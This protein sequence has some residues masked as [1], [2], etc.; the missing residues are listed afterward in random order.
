M[1]DPQRYRD[2]IAG[3]RES[4]NLTV[5]PPGNPDDAQFEHDLRNKRALLQAMINEPQYIF[6]REEMEAW[7]SK[8]Q[9]DPDFHGGTDDAGLI[10]IPS[11]GEQ[12]LVNHEAAK[13]GEPVTPLP[14]ITAGTGMDR[15]TTTVALTDGAPE[16]NRQDKGPPAGPLPRPGPGEGGLPA[17][18]A[19]PK[20]IQVPTKPHA[21][22]APASLAEF[23]RTLPA[24]GQDDHGDSEVEQ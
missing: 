19:K 15:R 10:Q 13:P 24:Y 5:R 17:P 11:K 16:V 3:M 2:R 1:A 20:P 4:S 22:R 9:N 18:P 7:L 23:M 12:A 14:E 6:Q 8:K 21:E